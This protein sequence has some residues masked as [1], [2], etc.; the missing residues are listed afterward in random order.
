MPPLREHEMTIR[1]SSASRSSGS[2]GGPDHARQ[3]ADEGADRGRVVVFLAESLGDRF[4]YGLYGAE[5]RNVVV[6][7]VLAH[8]GLLYL[9]Q[10]LEWV[11]LTGN[12]N[13]RHLPAP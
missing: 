6:W 12:A 10:G 5:E 7:V 1:E 2:A 3:G 13:R 8:R 4:G 9:D 11:V